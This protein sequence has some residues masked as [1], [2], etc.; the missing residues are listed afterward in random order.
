MRLG[1]I[2]ACVENEASCIRSNCLDV[3]KFEWDFPSFKVLPFRVFRN[4]KAKFN[5]NSDN[6]NLT[7]LIMSFLCSGIV[8]LVFRFLKIVFAFPVVATRL[9]LRISMKEEESSKGS[10]LNGKLSRGIS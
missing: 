4:F 10:E 8:E 9:I 3:D 7:T 1:L 5:S 2:I 6:S